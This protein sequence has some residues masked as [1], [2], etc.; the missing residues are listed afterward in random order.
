MYEYMENAW[1][2][3]LG[4]WQRKPPFLPKM[5]YFLKKKMFETKNVFRLIQA[6]NMFKHISRNRGVT[7][8][9]SRK[10]AHYNVFFIWGQKGHLWFFSKKWQHHKKKSYIPKS[11]YWHQCFSVWKMVGAKSLVHSWLAGPTLSPLHRLSWCMWVNNKKNTWCDLPH[12]WLAQLAG[13]DKMA[14][15]ITGW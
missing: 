15:S 13:I 5:L 12:L 3:I 10:K 1:W 9:A 11:V 7:N 4:P 6:P 2:W 14:G 8:K